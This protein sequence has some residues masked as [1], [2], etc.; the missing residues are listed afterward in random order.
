MKSPQ[1]RKQKSWTYLKQNE[2]N[3]LHPGLVH[4]VRQKHIKEMKE[5]KVQ[6]P[7]GCKTVTVKVD[8]EQ[9]ITEFEPEKKKFEPEDGDILS[10]VPF[11]L[12]KCML[13]YKGANQFGG[14]L[15]YAGFIEG[16]GM[17][18]LYI[19]ESGKY[20]G[21]GFVSQYPRHATEEEKQRLFDA[22][23]KDGKRW[24]AEKKRVEDL[25]RWRAEKN[26]EYYY[27]RADAE[28]EPELENGWSEDNTCYS[29]GNYFKTREAAERVAK[30]IREIFKNSKAE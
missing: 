4:P 26:E 5:I 12:C 9:V 20:N 16:L 7:E 28:V 18:K 27:V 23:A 2:R 29:I 21:Y 17:Q 3:N 24:N 14:I 25:P 10:G 6:V 15:A 22:L 11:P 1:S 19:S 30:Q 8:G 13:I